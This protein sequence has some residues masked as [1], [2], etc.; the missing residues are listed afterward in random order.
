[1]GY[2][3]GIILG[4]RKTINTNLAISKKALKDQFKKLIF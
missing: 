2:A 3:L 4:I 1:M